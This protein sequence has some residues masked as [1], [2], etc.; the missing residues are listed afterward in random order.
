MWPWGKRGESVGP[1]KKPTSARTRVSVQQFATEIGVWE[2]LVAAV[3]ASAVSSDLLSRI[4]CLPVRSSHATT[5]LGSYVSKD[6]QPVCIR[7]Q[8]NQEA[9]LLKETLLHEV[10]HACDHLD[11]QS[12][13]V[14]RRAHGPGWQAWMH[15]FGVPARTTGQSEE[16][17][18]LYHQRM[19]VVAV[20]RG[21]GAEIRRVRRLDR[22]RR[23]R[24]AAC[25]GVLKRL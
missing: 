24:H 3:Q 11:N 16:L 17:K 9:D 19:K 14:Y 12:G 21:C 1:G 18:Q 7:L 10:A 15:A 2:V 25:G 13:K 6:G 4:A 23:Y 5:R 22:R 8:M 20:C